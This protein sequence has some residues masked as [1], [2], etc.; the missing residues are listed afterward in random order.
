MPLCN[1]YATSRNGIFSCAHFTDGLLLLSART[2]EG[3]SRVT[4][5]LH[6]TPQDLQF[7]RE[8]LEQAQAPT[9]STEEPA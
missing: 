9:Q 1:R 2:G 8:E 5:T 3:N 7:L 4:A 6:L